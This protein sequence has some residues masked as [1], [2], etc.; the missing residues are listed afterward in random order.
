MKSKKTKQGPP[1][2]KSALFDEQK[3]TE[4]PKAKS[5]RIATGLGGKFRLLLDAAGDAVIVFNRDGAILYWNRAAEN[6]LGYKAEEVV[7][8]QLEV[9]V[10]ERYRNDYRNALESLKKK[11]N[12]RPINQSFESEAVKKDRQELPIAASI[13]TTQIDGSWYFVGIVRDITSLRASQSLVRETLAKYQLMIENQRNGILL[14]DVETQRLLE[15]NRVAAEMYGYSKG[16][17]LKMRVVDLFA[18]GEKDSR[19]TPESATMPSISKHKRKDGS[20]FMAEMTGGIVL[21][22]DRE[23]FCAAVRNASGD[24]S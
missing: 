1:I 24:K 9:I 17:M 11:K 6:I 15:A 13:S 12:L 7:G 16:E 18:E 2:I 8:L 22:E 5:G 10:P 4:S 21:W 14:V 20:V 23:T 19:L 3:S